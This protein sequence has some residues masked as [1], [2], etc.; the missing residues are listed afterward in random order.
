L[1]SKRSPA[2]SEADKL[3]LR[4]SEKKILLITLLQNG[5]VHSAS[6]EVEAFKDRDALAEELVQSAYPD[7]KVQLQHL[8]TFVYN[9]TYF[10]TSYLATN[11]LYQE[12]AKNNKLENKET[13]ALFYR[14]AS[15][16]ADPN[17]ET[18]SADFKSNLLELKTK[19]APYKC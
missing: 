14:T 11:A 4:L 19:L 5:D 1:R 7:T 13:L 12:L 17:F 15:V 2:S 18:Q 16:A 9:I 8:T 6:R 10:S 3:K